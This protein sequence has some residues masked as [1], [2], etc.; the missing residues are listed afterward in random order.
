MTRSLVHAIIMAK[1]IK[2]ETIAAHRNQRGTNSKGV[3]LLR[4]NLPSEH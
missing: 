3:G 1:V 4:H 2:V